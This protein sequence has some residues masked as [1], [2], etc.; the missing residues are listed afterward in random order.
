MT[1]RALSDL[2]PLR[3]ALLVERARAQLEGAD[4]LGAEPIAVIGMGCRFPGADDPEAYWSLLREGGDA[5]V[6]VPED[7]WSIARFFDP[8][9][10]APGRM[11]S[12]WGGFVSELRGFDADFF[13]ISPREVERMDPRQRMVLEVGWEAFESAGLTREQLRGSGRAL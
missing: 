4:T 6:E 11:N 3:L 8:D 1:H 7:R 2:S 10:S 9:P 13:A 12:R 5:I